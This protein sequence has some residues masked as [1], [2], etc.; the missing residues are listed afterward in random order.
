MKVMKNNMKHM[1][2]LGIGLLAAVVAACTAH[3]AA[4]A[5]A[6]SPTQT[7]AGTAR[8]SP[9]PGAIPDNIRWMQISAE[10]VGIA[11]QTY[12]LAAV[13][14]E[15]DAKGRA[16]GSWGVVLDADDTVINNLEY[17]A[18]LARDGVVHSADRFTAF[19]RTYTSTAV[20]G[21]AT[22]LSRVR[23]LGGRIA[24]VTN[25]LQI[26]CHDTAELLRRLSEVHHA[27]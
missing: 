8:P 26:E 27:K 5:P 16:P 2:T 19:V 23:A 17:Q 3:K 9:T 6:G 13:R 12:R 22:F 18:G 1:K 10:Y 14:V 15:A 20:P 21:A 11:V 24:I 25:R 4:P 7:P